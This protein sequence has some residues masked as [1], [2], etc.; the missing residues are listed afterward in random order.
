MHH[1]VGKPPSA[2][3]RWQS[4]PPVAQESVRSDRR[5]AIR[6]CSRC[7]S[8]LPSSTVM[9]NTARSATDRT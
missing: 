2:S 9:W 5:E 3:H 1:G 7:V 8:T 4:K 6:V